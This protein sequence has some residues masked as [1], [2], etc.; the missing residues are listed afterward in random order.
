[1]SDYNV[2]TINDGLNEFNV[3][4][5]GPKESIISSLLV[6]LSPIWYISFSFCVSTWYMMFQKLYWRGVVHVQAYCCKSMNELGNII[7]FTTDKIVSWFVVR[8]IWFH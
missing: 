2:E 5:H 4:F 6:F 8:I 1:M 7:C 3:E